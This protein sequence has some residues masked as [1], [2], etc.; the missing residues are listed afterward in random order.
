MRIQNLLLLVIL[1]IFLFSCSKDEIGGDHPGTVTISFKNDTVIGLNQTVTI[2]AVYTGSAAI[3]HRW[4]V[5]DSL[6][7][8]TAR[9]VFKPPVAGLYTIT[10]SGKIGEV[11]YTEF[12]KVTA[13]PKI[14]PVTDTSS[15]FISRVYEYLPA[16]GQFMGESAGSLDGAR[17]IIGDRTGLLS[18]GSFGGYVIFGFDH[19][20]VNQ[21]GADLA[22]Y[23]NPLPA[24]RDWSEPGIVLVSRDENENGLPDDT[25]YELAGSE[26][27]NASTIRNYSITYYNPRGMVNVPWKD[28]MGNTGVVEIN[29]FHQ[30]SYYPAFVANQDS[31]T[32]TGSRL[33][34]TFGE[35][36]GIYINRAFAWGYADNYATDATK[37]PYAVNRYN[38]F[39]LSWAVDRNGTVVSLRAID[40]VKVYTGQNN[41]GYNLMGEVSTE[42]SGAADLNMR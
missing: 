33:P 22:I 35:Q 3:T 30:H 31:L 12:L 1:V 4:T 19:S 21:A 10:Y 23:G 8:T 36:D 9:L 34:A 29:E 6:Y 26:Y 32:F 37:D 14:R 16:P 41:K 17:S 27:K 39:D 24:P 5:N 42:I 15:R 18:L 7:A 28:N 20:I 40:F 25:W 2:E 11:T 38:V 13:E